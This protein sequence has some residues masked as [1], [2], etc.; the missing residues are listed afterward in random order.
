[1]SLM[2]LYRAQY[3]HRMDLNTS[4]AGNTMVLEADF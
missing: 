3:S 2:I 4:L 1:M